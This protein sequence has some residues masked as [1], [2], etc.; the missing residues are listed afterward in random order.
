M[1]TS[2]KKLVDWAIAANRLNNYFPEITDGDYYDLLAMIEKHRRAQNT[3]S[4]KRKE[5][6]D[7]MTDLPVFR[8]TSIDGERKLYQYASQSKK[9]LSEVE[10]LVVYQ[11]FNGEYYH[12]IS[13]N[14]LAERASTTTYG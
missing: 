3:P 8:F 12:W 7:Y 1:N 10:D 9:Y 6:I 4:V 2:L 13:K 5:F 11:G 14:V